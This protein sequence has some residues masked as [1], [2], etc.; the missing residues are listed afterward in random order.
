MSPALLLAR[1]AFLRYLGLFGSI[2]CAIDGYLFGAAKDL[3]PNVSVATIATGANG[4]LILVLWIVGL[5]S[6]CTAWWYGRNLDGLSTRWVLVTALLWII[7]MLVIPPLASRDVYAYACQGQLFSSGHNPYTQS[8]ADQPCPWLTSVSP[9]WRTT[10]TPYGPIFIMLSGLAASLGSQVAAI[11]AYRVLAVLGLAVTAIFLPRLA[12]QLGVPAQR[13]TW[14]LLCCPLISV[15]IVGGAHNDALTIAFMVAGLALIVAAKRE[16]GALIA[17]GV[18]LGAAFSVKITLGVMLP[19]A[20]LLAAGPVFTGA[21]GR[22][23]PGGLRDLVTRGGAVMVSALA[24]LVGLSYA[25]GLGLGWIAAMSDAGNSRSWTSPSTSV[26]MFVHSVVRFFGPRID[27]VP[28]ARDAALL[29]L[30]AAL[31]AILWHSRNRNPLYGGALA[32]IALILL[33]PITQPWYLLWPL[34]LVAV[35]MMRARWLAIAIVASM[36]TILPD[37]DGAMKPLQTPLS[38][39]MT[40]LLVITGVRFVQW[41]RGAEPVEDKL[42]RLELQPDVAPVSPE[43]ADSESASASASRV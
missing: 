16:Y 23:R 27:F 42:T 29:V 38:Y 21:R 25:S 43:P 1:P 5:G 4:L 26:G 41:L 28:W 19:F 31:V 14:L 15:H 18:L 34:A 11:V 12:R 2:C 13:A 37:G 20:A 3:R 30:A 17:G 9:V 33:A 8:V 22:L 6:I 7:P 39:V 35:T 32:L 36:F 40:G 10:S 24:T